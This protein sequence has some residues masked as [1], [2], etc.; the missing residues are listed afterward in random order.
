MAGTLKSL[1]KAAAWQENKGLEG[2]AHGKSDR[3]LCTDELLEACEVASSAATGKSARVP[4][5][6][7]EVRLILADVR[8]FCIKRFPTFAIGEKIALL[9]TAVTK[10]VMKFLLAGTT[11]LIL[12]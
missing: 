8:V 11:V 2:L 7:D 9:N 3:V 10:D 1:G 12:D 4:S 6:D 5:A